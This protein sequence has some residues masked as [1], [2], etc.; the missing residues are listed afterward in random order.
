MKKVY[1]IGELLIDFV[2]NNG[3]ELQQETRGSSSKCCS[4]N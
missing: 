4:G 3:E 1:C 2:S